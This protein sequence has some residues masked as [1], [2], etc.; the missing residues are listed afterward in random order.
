MWVAPP[1]L[2]LVMPLQCRCSG[3][4]HAQ[5]RAPSGWPQ[6]LLPGDSLPLLGSAFLQNG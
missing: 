1:S 2:T 6:L 5:S 4:T 3:S